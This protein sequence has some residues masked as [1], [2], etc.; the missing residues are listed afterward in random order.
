MQW[1]PKP[2]DQHLVDLLTVGLRSDPPEIV[3]E[4][5]LGTLN[6]GVR[7]IARMPRWL[8]GHQMPEEL[9]PTSS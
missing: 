2:T 5:L 9:I 6:S 4:A 3:A 1:T 7:A 8:T